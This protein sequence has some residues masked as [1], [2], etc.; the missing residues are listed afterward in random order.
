ME[1]FAAGA[2]VVGR[3]MQDKGLP[4]GLQA[5]FIDPPA[6][7]PEA[8]AFRP[9][10]HL[11]A[12]V[13]VHVKVVQVLAQVEAVDEE[14]VAPAVPEGGTVIGLDLYVGAHLLVKTV[15]EYLS[16]VCGDI[17]QQVPLTVFQKVEAADPADAH[18]GVLVQ[19]IYFSPALYITLPED[20]F[21]GLCFTCC[22]EQLDRRG[23]AAD[24]HASYG[25]MDVR[26]QGRPVYLQVHAGHQPF[27]G[28]G[29][30]PVRSHLDAV[31]HGGH[32]NSRGELVRIGHEIAVGLGFRQRAAG[33]FVPQ[34]RRRQNGIG[35]VLHQPRMVGNHTVF[36]YQLPGRYIHLLLQQPV[37]VEN[38]QVVVR[39]PVFVRVVCTREG[40][41]RG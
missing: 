37:G 31:Q 36:H 18:A 3:R 28:K 27:Q 24:L 17:L 30:L 22:F 39:N 10:G 41:S 38:E 34:V 19:R 16:P 14:T 11:V 4:S 9:Y 32:G 15:V 40:T 1:I 7:F 12:R 29:K 2:L 26:V 8:V 5:T 33:E 20:V 21:P 6:V 35:H 23:A 13:P 25:K